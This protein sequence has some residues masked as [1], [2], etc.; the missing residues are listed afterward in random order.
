MSGVNDEELR[1][2]L[3]AH[4]YKVPPIT[5]TTRGLLHKKLIALDEK[6]AKSKK[7]KQCYFNEAI[8]V[9]LGVYLIL[10]KS[11]VFKTFYVPF[12]ENA[13][14]SRRFGRLHC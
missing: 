8:F 6:N 2:R 10:L 7:G 5:A 13:N 11:H 9:Y 12:R 1:E 3:E 14:Y 4:N